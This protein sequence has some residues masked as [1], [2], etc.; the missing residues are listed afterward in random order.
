MVPLPLTGAVTAGKPLADF[1]GPAEFL[2]LQFVQTAVT[3]LLYC[4]VISPTNDKSDEQV[5]NLQP[6]LTT[7]FS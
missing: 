4:L 1:T 2:I 6:I 5:K 7:A 3:V